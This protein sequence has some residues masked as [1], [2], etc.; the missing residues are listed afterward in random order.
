MKGIAAVYGK[1]DKFLE[2][3]DRFRDKTIQKVAL[4]FLKQESL[5]QEQ[6]QLNLSQDRGFTI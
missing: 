5:T 1:D 3:I 6:N 2:I 4:D